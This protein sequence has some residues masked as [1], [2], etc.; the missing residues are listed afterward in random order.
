MS[1]DESPREI[2]SIV[3]TAISGSIKIV[4]GL[5]GAYVNA[6]WSVRSSK[7]RF[8]KSLVKHGLPVDY[9]KELAS[10]YAAAGR[11]ILSIRKMVSMIGKMRDL[12]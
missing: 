6:R 3:W 1:D 2:A 5:L 11:D 12:E 8:Q 7:R 9:A 10:T 4:A